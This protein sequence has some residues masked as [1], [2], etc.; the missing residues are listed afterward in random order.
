MTKAEMERHQADHDA[1]LDE[2][3]FALQSRS[4]HKAIA[5]AVSSWQYLDG[6]MQYER[7]Y[8]GREFTRLESIDIVLRL[9]PLLF[10][11][12]SLD[13]LA[14][15]LKSQ[16][17]IDKNASADLAADLS[18]A[19]SL[20][21]QAHKLWNHLQQHPGFRQDEL[22]T[23]LGD[24]Q[25]RWRR[26]S[27]AW[28]EMGIIRRAPERGSYRLTFATRLDM[29]VLGK[30]PSCGALC[31]ARKVKLLNEAKCP[32]CGTETRFVILARQLDS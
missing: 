14:S 17:R 15:L 22:R 32:K 7:K 24:D 29:R 4:W 11:L 10:D 18:K 26:L 16:R 8:E 30:C 3:R 31:K 28:E 2:A 27:E 13:K 25:E 23:T 21:W 5:F 6:M 1:T 12:S 20:V 9:A 19:R